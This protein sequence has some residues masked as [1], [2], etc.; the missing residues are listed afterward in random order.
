MTSNLLK[1]RTDYWSADK[2]DDVKMHRKNKTDLP[3]DMK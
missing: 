1:L 3:R 2:S